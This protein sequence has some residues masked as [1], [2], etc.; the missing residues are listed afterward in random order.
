MKSCIN[1][2][3][4]FFAFLGTF[5]FLYLIVVVLELVEVLPGD[6][7]TVVLTLLVS[8]PALLYVYKV[9]VESVYVPSENVLV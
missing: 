9:V 3:M 4:F 5:I 2:F 8:S 1:A 6:T 7:S